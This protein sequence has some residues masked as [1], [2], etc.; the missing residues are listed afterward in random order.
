MTPKKDSVSP[1]G[2]TTDKANGS[3]TSQNEVENSPVEMTSKS[4][5]IS[6]YAVVTF[7]I[8]S[9]LLLKFVSSSLNYLIIPL[10]RSSLVLCFE[11]QIKP[12]HF[13]THLFVLV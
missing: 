6:P 2:S 11:N 13:S 3:E 4:S 12:L 10:A 9:L 1:S 5:V 8:T 7:T